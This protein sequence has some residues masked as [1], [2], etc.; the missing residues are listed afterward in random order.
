MTTQKQQA[1]DRKARIATLKAT[2]AKDEAVLGERK[3]VCRDL[4]GVAKA[5]R[6]LKL[7]DEQ[8]SIDLLKLELA[9]LI[10]GPAEELA[11]ASSVA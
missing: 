9:K 11:P 3:A 7:G 1:L 2:I 6:T 4:R 5:E 10:E 8:R